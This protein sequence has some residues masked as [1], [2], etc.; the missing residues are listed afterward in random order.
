MRI[1][2]PLLL[3]ALATVVA[4]ESGTGPGFE[5]NIVG[6][7]ETVNYTE[8]LGVDLSQ[9]TRSPTGL[10]FRDLTVG[11][12]ESAGRNQTAV[13][14]YTGW[15]A[16]GRRFD[17][18]QLTATLDGES[19]I[20]GFTEGI[21]GMRVGGR[22]LMVIP[23]QLGYGESAQGVIPPGAVLIFEAELLAVSTPEP[24]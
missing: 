12:G 13:V 23:P 18:G 21:I 14:R 4:C 5:G 19:L 3:A 7:P 8:A 9:M 17:S 6:Q 15:L 11:G 22:R 2:R 20:E 24:E 10:Y 1:L 16:N